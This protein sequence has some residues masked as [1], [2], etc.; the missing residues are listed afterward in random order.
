MLFFYYYYC[1]IALCIVVK[2]TRNWHIIIFKRNDKN[3]TL[4]YIFE[5]FAEI[6]KIYL[7]FFKIIIMKR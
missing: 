5:Y 3:R 2:E 4:V 1:V 6:L 7:I